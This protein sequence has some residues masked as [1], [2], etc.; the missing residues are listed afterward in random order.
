MQSPAARDPSD[1]LELK[2]PQGRFERWLRRAWWLHS[3]FALGFGVFVML[4]ARKG[5]AYADKLLMILP[6]SWLLLF[7]ALRF[8]VGPA[9]T[10][11]DE[12]VAKRGLRVVTNYIIKN[13]YQQMFFFLVPLYAASATWSMASR[14]FWLPPLLLACAVLSTL[15]VI[16]D[17]FIMG[18]RRL[19][20]VMYGICLFGVLN[21]MLP[22]VF[23]M[24]HLHALMIAAAT[25]APAI[26]LLS[27]NV[28]DVFSAKGLGL[29]LAAAA[30][31]TIAAWV[32]R[33][34]IP[35]APLALVE[36]AVGHGTPGS[37]EG[38]PGKKLYLREEQ[39]DGLR[40]GTL[41]SEP[42]GIHDDLVHVWRHNGE[43]VSR[44]PVHPIDDDDP[45]TVLMRSV[46]DLVPPNAGGRWTCSLE[47]A[48]GQLVGVVPF[49][50][51]PTDQKI[52]KEKVEVPPDGGVR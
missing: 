42:G 18:R 43:L 33:A 13:L 50:V 22:M 8:I 3:F 39:L 9:N 46:P 26:A 25:T 45:T 38:L 41:A 37:Y 2:R 51:I 35:P 49:T 17:H 6:I 7:I 34:A 5:L 19:A 10:S 31:L 36:G 16:F 23:G 29:T 28:R 21:L 40:C 14:N 12:R 1:R 20:S 4:F 11:P 44:V 47:T 48:D 30:G 32:G 52:P 24:T 27:F 15:D